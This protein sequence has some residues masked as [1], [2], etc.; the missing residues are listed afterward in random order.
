[1]DPTA[2]FN[3][4]IGALESKD[5]SEAIQAASDLLSWYLAKP[6]TSGAVVADVEARDRMQTLM[7]QLADS[8]DYVCPAYG[9][10][11]PRTRD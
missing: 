5:D 11:W 9:C 4:L 2:C 10:G 7:A 3:R 6:C 8:Q 1:M